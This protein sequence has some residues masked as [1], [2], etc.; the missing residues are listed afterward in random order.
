MASGEVYVATVASDET[1]RADF[2]LDAASTHSSFGSANRAALTMRFGSREELLCASK[3]TKSGDSPPSAR[4]WPLTAFPRR[5]SSAG[6][7]GGGHPQQPALPRPLASA[8]Q[9]GIAWDP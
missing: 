9:N 2:I 5:S 3:G 1:S 7:T 6:T 4:V 8:V